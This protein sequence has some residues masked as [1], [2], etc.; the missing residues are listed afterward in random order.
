MPLPLVTDPDSASELHD[1]FDLYDLHFHTRHSDGLATVSEAIER[2]KQLKIRLS[3]TDHNVIGGAMDACAVDDTVVPAIEVT[4]AERIHLL[5]YFRAADDLRRFYADSI[6]PFRAPG[7]SPLAPV[8]R[9]VAELMEDLEPYD[10]LTSAAHPFAVA[11]N[12]WMT[13][14]DKH[15]HILPLLPDIDAVEA[16]NGQELDGG[17]TKARAFAREQGRSVT[18]GSDGHTLAELG[19]VCLVVPQGEDL[20]EVVRAGA[21]LLL[22]LRPPGSWRRVAVQAAKAPY[23]ARQTSR[24]FRNL[25]SS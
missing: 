3:I 4:T 7:A 21:G 20:F 2:A 5:I 6:A 17:N 10:H 24:I 16:I 13:V 9:P 12:G 19:R 15:N 18:A 25:F 11:K 1:S 22:D 23:Y 8:A 14:R